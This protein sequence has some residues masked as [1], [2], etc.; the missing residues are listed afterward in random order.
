MLVAVLASCGPVP[1]DSF[2][3]TYFGSLLATGRCD[4]GAT[5]YDASNATLLVT[6][7][8]SGV[9]G[10]DFIE[11]CPGLTAA[12]AGRVGTIRPSTCPAIK[13][14]GYTWVHAVDSGRIT[15]LSSGD[16]DVNMDGTVTRTAI[17]IPPVTCAVRWQNT[18]ILQQ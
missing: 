11:F 9:L 1:T 16:A 8:G 5:T 17:D 6:A 15:F 10:V 18:L 14:Q 7:D 13:R 2:A 3:G 4:N 12:L